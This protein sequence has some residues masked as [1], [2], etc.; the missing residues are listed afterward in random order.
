MS[1]ITSMQFKH[2]CLTCGERW[3]T[4]ALVKWDHKGQ[5]TLQYPEEMND[6]LDHYLNSELNWVCHNGR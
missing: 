2:E 3:E 6:R 1:V 5:L 4:T